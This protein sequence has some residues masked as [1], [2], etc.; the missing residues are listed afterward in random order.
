MRPPR[1]VAASLV[2]LAVGTLSAC[3]PPAVDQVALGRW[4]AD[5][6]ARGADD[7]DVTVFTANAPAGS[8]GQR[9]SADF[10]EPRVPTS[11]TFECF[12]EGTISLQVDGAADGGSSSRTTTVGELDCA[13]G[14]HEI[15]PGAVG[16]GAVTGVGAIAYRPDRDTAWS[17]TVHRDRFVP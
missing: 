12:G 11:I 2:V 1:L 9:I 6:A 10:P 13:D 8:P 3:S 17:L 5:R 4:Q 14:P 16:P 15:D 7:P